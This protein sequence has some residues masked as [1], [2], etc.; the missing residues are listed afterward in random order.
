[1]EGW[2]GPRTMDDGERRRLTGDAGWGMERHRLGREILRFTQDRLS[3]VK[4]RRGT[5][6]EWKVGRVEDWTV[7]GG[8]QKP[9]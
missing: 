5:G 2:D 8:R 3:R 6:E 1:M 4:G 7:E 9:G